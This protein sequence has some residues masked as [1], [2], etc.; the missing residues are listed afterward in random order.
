[1]TE[2]PASITYSSVVSRDSVRLCLLIAALNSLDVLSCD[3]Q[4]AYLTAPSREKVVITAGPEFG[5]EL[6]GKILIVTRALYGLKSAGAAFR[7]YLA[8]YLHR[9]DLRKTCL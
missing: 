6:E 4:G 7:S 1:M 8:D 9:T 2:A 3:I 5:T